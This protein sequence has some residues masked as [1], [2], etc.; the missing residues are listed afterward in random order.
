MTASSASGICTA[1]S[2]SAI[3][4][5]RVSPRALH[6]KCRCRRVRCARIRIIFDNLDGFDDK[7]FAFVESAGECLAPTSALKSP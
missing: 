2:T 1:S 5:W 7:R 4:A 6:C 3:S